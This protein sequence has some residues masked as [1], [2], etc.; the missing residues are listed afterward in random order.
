MENIKLA[1]DA[2]K[3]L[4]DF[5]EIEKTIKKVVTSKAQIEL[6]AL[7]RGLITKV[8]ENTKKIKGE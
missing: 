1:E 5:I 3:H 7:S 4:K 2:I 8:E 6:Y